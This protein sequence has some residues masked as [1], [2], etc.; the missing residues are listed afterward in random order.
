MQMT[1]LSQALF[2]LELSKNI[3]LIA[4][5]KGLF[6][7]LNNCW[8]FNTFW[9]QIVFLF[10]FL[11]S[12][13]WI[14]RSFFSWDYS[15]YYLDWFGLVCSF[16]FLVNIYWYL[17]V[18]DVISLIKTPFKLFKPITKGIFEEIWHLICFLLLCLLFE[19]FTPSFS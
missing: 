18:N 11:S 6:W 5:L 4:F 16:S 2:S 19:N 8:F 10:Y 1:I 9:F 17:C 13:W 15:H 14:Y 3:I 7:N 12:C